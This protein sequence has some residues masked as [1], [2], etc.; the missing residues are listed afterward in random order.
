MTTPTDVLF[1]WDGLGADLVIVQNDLATDGGL[2]TAVLLSLFSDR[3]A[4]E[5]DVLPDGQTDRRGWWGDVLSEID[6]DRIGS[7]LWLLGREK[8][9]PA[10]LLRAETYAREALQW[11]LDDRV[12]E[13]ITVTASMGRPV[14]PGW[15]ILEVSIRRPAQT[16]VTFRFA[17]AWTAQAGEA[18]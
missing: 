18:A 8:E 9:L 11:L 2:Q 13:A 10:V 14:R 15:L 12:A 16:P 6:Q 7:K 17:H 5:T 1:L 4:A 3:R